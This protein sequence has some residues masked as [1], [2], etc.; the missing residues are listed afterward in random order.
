MAWQII[1]NMLTSPYLQQYPPL[2]HF[3]PLPATYHPKQRH[4]RMALSWRA[5][6]ARAH[7]CCAISEK[8]Q[9]K[10]IYIYVNSIKTKHVYM[11]RMAAHSTTGRKRAAYHFC[12]QR[13]NGKTSLSTKTSSSPSSASSAASRSEKLS[14]GGVAITQASAARAACATISKWRRCAR[15]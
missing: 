4:Q 9:H 3:A 8:W 1:N 15:K 11:S 6:S 13:A 14:I 2:Y 5:R 10:S 7:R 12:D